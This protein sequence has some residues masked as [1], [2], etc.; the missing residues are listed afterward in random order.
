MSQVLRTASGSV[1]RARHSGAAGTLAG[2]ARGWA[3]IAVGALAV[4]GLFAILL[5]VSRIPGMENAPRWPIGFFYNGL[6][7][8]VVFSLVIWLLGVFAFLST[9]AAR[10]A[11]AGPMRA[12][13]L[14][15]V[16][17]GLALAAFP[18]LFGPSFLNSATPALTTSAK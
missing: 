14:G 5:A 16:G 8:H 12:A 11:A 9:I 17:Q 18:F 15:R 1:T 4:A 2:E 6:V 13:W 7:I 10:E 3:W